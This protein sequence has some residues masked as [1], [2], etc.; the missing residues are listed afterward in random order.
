M[1]CVIE[2]MYTERIIAGKMQS[3]IKFFSVISMV[4]D[5]IKRKKLT[6]GCFKSR[7]NYDITELGWENGQPLMHEHVGILPAVPDSKTTWDRTDD[8]LESIVHQATYPNVNLPEFDHHL[9]QNH[10]LTNKNSIVTPST[11]IWGEN[12]NHVEMSPPV[13][14]KKRVQSSEHSDQCRGMNNLTISHQ[15]HADKRPCGSGSA[16]FAKNNDATMMTWA[17]LESPR[18]MR[19]KTKPVD[20]DSACHAGSVSY[21]YFN[22]VTLCQTSNGDKIL[23]FLKKR[24]LIV[25]TEYYRCIHCSQL[26]LSTNSV[27]V[28][29][30]RKFQMKSL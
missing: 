2:A 16:T 10:Q 28:I 3:T 25:Y 26:G 5:K 9:N 11:R 24:N 18:S 13:Y 15:N 8:T 30:N 6:K 21:K 23:F 29:F 20:E 1:L 14:T 17:S 19:S 7:S 22:K 27:L 4:Y 12:S